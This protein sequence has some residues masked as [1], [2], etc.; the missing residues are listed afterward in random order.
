MASQLELDNLYMEMAYLNAALS[1]AHR[2]KVG[3]V[4]VNSQDVV[5]TGYNGTPKN[6][7]NDCEYKVKEGDSVVLVTKPEVIHAELNCVIKAA[8]DGVSVVNGTLYVTI[9][10]CVSCSALLIQSGITRLVYADEYRNSLGIDLLKSA[11]VQIDR[12]GIKD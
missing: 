6:L 7:N 12:L 3:A 11:N 9:A 5:L 10:P 1:K 2:R 8:R 4:L